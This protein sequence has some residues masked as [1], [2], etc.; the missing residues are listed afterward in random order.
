MSLAKDLVAWDGKQTEPLEKI[1]RTQSASPKFIEQLTVMLSA[2]ELQGGA[3]W[4]LKHHLEQNGRLTNDCISQIYEELGSLETWESKLHVLQSLPM[5]PIPDADV[6]K[7][8]HWLEQCLEEP[9]KF[10][11]AWAYNGFYELAKQ[12]PVHRRAVKKLLEQ[13]L[14]AES[15]A[16]VQARIRRCLKQGF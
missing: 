10:V 2:V 12:H 4:L 13:A 7:V 14:Q 11:R 8:R 15:A 9:N 5:L 3:S 16:S 6:Q 1:Y